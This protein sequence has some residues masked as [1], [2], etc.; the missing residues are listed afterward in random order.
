MRAAAT[1]KRYSP[2]TP[3]VKIGGNR[4]RPADTPIESTLWP[5]EPAAAAS[6]R[7]EE[8]RPAQVLE[9]LRVNV[10]R[11]AATLARYTRDLMA[12]GHG[13]AGYERVGQSSIQYQASATAV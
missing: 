7:S 2:E 5:H 1:T 12:L 4:P 8:A 10:D 9:Y 13:A 3:A 6:K 11:M